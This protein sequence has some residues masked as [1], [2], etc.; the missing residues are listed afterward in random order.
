MQQAKRY[1]VTAALPYAN[2]PLHI[3]HI[4]GAYLP[5]DIFVRYLRSQEEDV[6]F[7]CGSDEHGAAITMQAKKEGV[8][9]RTI[10]DRYHAINQEAFEG[11]GIGFDIYHRTSAPLHYE[12]AREFFHELYM[13]GAFTK[14]TKDQYYDEKASQ[15]LADRYIK[16]KCPNCGAQGAYGDQC[17]SCGSSL[18]PN[19]LIEPVSTLTGEKPVL[20][21]TS[22]WYLPLDQHE[23][24]LREYIRDGKLDGDTHHDPNEWKEHVKGQCMSW[25]DGGLQERAMT[26][27][28]DWG[29]PIPIEDEEAEGKVLYVW[30]DAPIGYISATKE[31]AKSH[32]RDWRPYWQ[33]R[34]SKLIHFIGKDNIVFHCLIFPIILKLYGHDFLLPHNVPANGFLNLEGDKIS[35][36]KNWAVWVNE[37]LE[38]L[39]GK[40]DVLRYTLT[41]N[42]PEYRDSEFTWQDLQDKNNNELVGILGN[43]VNRAVVLTHKHFEGK[44]PP[45]SE[46]K[47]IDQ[48]LGDELAAYPGTIGNL[49]ERYRFKEA[50]AEMMNFARAGNKYLADTEP[51][52]LIKEDQERVGTILH[53]ALQICADLVV[54]CK[55]FLPFS[56]ERLQGMLRIGE[57]KEGRWAD[58]GNLAQLR[59][60]HRIGE[61]QLLFQKL[62]DAEVEE[63]RE[64]LQKAVLE[65]EGDEDDDGGNIEDEAPREDGT[66]EIKEAIA[67]EDWQKLDLRVGEIQKAEPVEGADKLLKLEVSLG[68]EERSLVAGAA[69][70]FRPEELQGKRICVLIN[71]EPKK[72]KGILSEGMVLM[73]D[74]G[75]GKLSFLTPDRDLPAGSIVQ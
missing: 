75:N 48:Q 2:G 8:D 10:I 65:K 56:A 40:Q 25:I 23:D 42:A 28:L 59:E 33:D 11:L 51:W 55:P 34:D 26:R 67:F 72:I 68:T 66:A 71:L 52:H 22:H 5:S 4:A 74:D 20:R 21:S 31:W 37:Y 6:L 69:K 32:G 61:Q 53:N 29:V 41:A 49:I 46:S 39:P 73:A 70:N 15:F 18:S 9:P 54:L 7:I 64:K 38:D 63:Q 50:Q 60:G 1:T 47:P 12:T 19:E 43:F 17:E 13:K 35:T 27:D 58:A 44:V 36:S 57:G 3:G 24:W 45:K 30:L 62:K 16:G 14:R